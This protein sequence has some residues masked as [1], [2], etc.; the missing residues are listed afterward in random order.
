M[1]EKIPL[2]LQAHY[3]S[4]EQYWMYVVRGWDQEKY[5]ESKD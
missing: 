3:K 4:I 5:L 2:I 1:S